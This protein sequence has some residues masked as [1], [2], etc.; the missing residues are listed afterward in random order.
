L[1]IKLE[2]HERHLALAKPP[3]NL[4]AY[5]YYL[6][7]RHLERSFNRSERARA[8]DIFVKAI[9][10]DPSYSRGYLGLAWYELRN[11]KWGEPSNP[12]AALA[13]AYDAAVTATALDPNDAECHWVLG[14][15]HLW[16]KDPG[17]ALACYERAR[18]LCPNHADLLADLCDTLTYL[19]RFEEAIE[20]GRTSLRL[21]PDQP[22][23]YLWNVAAGY[24]LSG[25]YNAALTYLQQMAQPGPAYRLIA[26]TYGQLGYQEKAR[27]A[28]AELL[29]I[30]PEFSI[31]RFA[32][33]APYTN[34]DDLARYVAGLRL[35]GL[36]E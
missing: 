35:A 31:S 1:K 27:Q 5:D 30:N 3:T 33:Q 9:E 13:C 15:L 8:R 23:W 26:A 25:H 19:G 28:A 21:N 32:A 22:D 6:R 14:L 17:R 11:L 12:D 34:P 20:V 4:V 10:A 36:P 18:M 29:K 24:Y 16:K 7:G 2:D